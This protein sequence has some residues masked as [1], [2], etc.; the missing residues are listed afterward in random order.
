MFA[1]KRDVSFNYTI[2]ETI[3]CGIVL[4]GWE[5]KSI[6]SGKCSIRESYVKII[7]DEVFLIGAHIAP[8]STIAAK[9]SNVDATRSKKLLLNRAEINKLAVKIHQK[10]LTLIPL[11]VHYNAKNKLKL[12]I[13]LCEGKKNFDK[14]DAE[15]NRKIDL[16]LKR[17][18]K[19][20]KS[21]L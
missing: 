10:G 20:Q 3:E 11:S 13:A 9:F 5:V 16:D 19:S 17:I 7:N 14:R 18:V 1:E 21:I 6:I 12:D 8:I 2:L 15:K 4:E